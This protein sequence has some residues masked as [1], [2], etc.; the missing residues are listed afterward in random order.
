MLRT[1]MSH[2]DK[3]GLRAD[4]SAICRSHF[5]TVSKMSRVQS[6]LGRNSGRSRTFWV[7]RRISSGVAAVMR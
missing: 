7:I 5:Q 2:F 1:M 4:H 6:S 3:S